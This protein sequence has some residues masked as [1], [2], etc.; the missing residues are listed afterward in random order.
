MPSDQ[1]SGGTVPSGVDARL[2]QAWIFLVVF[3]A[4]ALTVTS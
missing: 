2:L 1:Q 4:S 3:S